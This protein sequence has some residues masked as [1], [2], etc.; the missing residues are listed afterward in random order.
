MERTPHASRRAVIGAIPLAA[1]ITAAPAAALIGKLGNPSCVER[2]EWEAAWLCYDEAVKADAAFNLIFDEADAR[3]TAEHEAIPHMD[4]PANP[5]FGI[6]E[7]TTTANW[8]YIRRA[9]EQIAADEGRS[10]PLTHPRAIEC[11]RLCVEAVAV[12]DARNARLQAIDDRLGYDATEQRW[13]DL[14]ERVSEARSALMSLP[15]PDLPA[16]A[17]KLEYLLRDDDGGGCAA[18]SNDFLIQPRA[19]IARLLGGEAAHA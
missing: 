1:L 9:K 17:W 12:A 6:A 15:A 11:H 3:R 18:W 8:Y 2:R 16:L 5:S 13:T 4:L 19:D 14:G 7:P 10:T